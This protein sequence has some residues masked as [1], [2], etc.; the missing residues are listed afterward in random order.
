MIQREANRE[1]NYWKKKHA[2]KKR[3]KKERE[4]VIEKQDETKVD[5]TL[6]WPLFESWT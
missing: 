6:T 4:N 5:F 3:K 2:G 1:E